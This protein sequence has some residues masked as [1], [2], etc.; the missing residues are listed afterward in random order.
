MVKVNSCLICGYPC[1]LDAICLH[2][3][4]F[5]AV[6]LQFCIF[7]LNTPIFIL[8]IVFSLLFDR[9]CKCLFVLN[10]RRKKAQKNDQPVLMQLQLEKKNYCKKEARSQSFSFLPSHVSRVQAW[11]EDHVSKACNFFKILCIFIMWITQKIPKDSRPIMNFS[12]NL[13]KRISSL[14]HIT[15]C[16]P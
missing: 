13:M 15:N 3:W 16:P 5:I 9:N 14:I 4:T 7:T 6:L 11:W 8:L 10:V 2:L 12:N 1:G